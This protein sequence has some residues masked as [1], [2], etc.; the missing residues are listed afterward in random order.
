MEANNVCIEGRQKEHLD[1]K[2][3]MLVLIRSHTQLIEFQKL[4]KK[5]GLLEQAATATEEQ[6]FRHMAYCS[7]KRA[8]A[9]KGLDCN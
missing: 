9:T 4:T 5:P 6:Q 8:A 3:W 2:E 7:F 1:D